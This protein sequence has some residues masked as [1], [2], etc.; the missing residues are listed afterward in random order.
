[1]LYIRGINLSELTCWKGLNIARPHRIFY[2]EAVSRLTEYK[3]QCLDISLKINFIKIC[4]LQF[5]SIYVNLLSFITFSFVS[6]VLQ[7]KLHEKAQEL[8][9]MMVLVL[10]YIIITL[11][12]VFIYIVILKYIYVYTFILI[13]KSKNNTFF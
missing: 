3:V 1:M 13:Q 7:I 2:F 10:I 9:L 6:K 8:Y 12:Y 11:L 5:D 4:V